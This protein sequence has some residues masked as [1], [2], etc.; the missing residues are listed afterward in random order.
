MGDV[1]GLHVTVQ[2]VPARMRPPGKHPDQSDERMAVVGFSERFGFDRIGIISMIQL[3]TTF[4]L[5][6][7]SVTF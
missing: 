7:F 2:N 4:S 5:L 1:P 6:H 3:S